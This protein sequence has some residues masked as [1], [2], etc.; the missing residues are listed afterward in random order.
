MI[1]RREPF[2]RKEVPAVT[3]WPR[4]STPDPVAAASRGVLSGHKRTRQDTRPA[5]DGRATDALTA[6]GAAHGDRPNG[7]ADTYA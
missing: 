1:A 4:K 3:A 6:T 7:S 5:P 2:P